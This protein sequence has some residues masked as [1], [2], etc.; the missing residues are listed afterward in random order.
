[1]YGRKQYIQNWVLFAVLGIH[2]ESR[3]YPLQKRENYTTS[4]NFF[5]F[6]YVLS[7]ANHIS[8]HTQGEGITQRCG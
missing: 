1:M 8:V 6:C 7:E 5:G 2:W 3:T 4:P